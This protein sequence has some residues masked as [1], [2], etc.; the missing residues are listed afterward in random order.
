MIDNLNVTV[1]ELYTLGKE[2]LS[3]KNISKAIEFFKKGE[4]RGSVE[5]QKELDRIYNEDLDFTPLEDFNDIETIH[6]LKQGAK[7]NDPYSLYKLGILY[8]R[9]TYVIKDLDRAFVLLTKASEHKYRDS[10]KYLEEVKKE[11]GI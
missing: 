4:A 9:G 11:L 3:K 7:N 1:E 5:C 10:Y 2:Y 8:L 6:T